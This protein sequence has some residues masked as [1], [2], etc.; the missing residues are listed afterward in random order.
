MNR[1]VH[2]FPSSKLFWGVYTRGVRVSRSF[3]RDESSFGD[4]KGAGGRGALGVVLDV[5]VRGLVAS[6]SHASQGCQ[7][8]TLLKLK[9]ADLDGLEEVEFRNSHF[10]IELL[11]C[12]I[13]V[14]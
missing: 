4:E 13:S 11:K 1:R 2:F 3:G 14:G 5:N 7:G 9:G 10:R 12:W 6:S 8:N